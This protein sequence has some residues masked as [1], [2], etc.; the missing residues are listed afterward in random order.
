M[1]DFSQSLTQK[2]DII[3]ERWVEQVRQGRQIESALD[4]SQTALRNAIPLVLGAMGTVLSSSPEDDDFG[5]IVDGSLEHGVC[6]AH[7]G[8]NSAEIAWEYRLLRRTIFSTL[9]PD[10][11]QGSPQEII[12]AFRIING[13]VDQA[14]SQC[15]QSYVQARLQDLEQLQA[16]LSLTN[17][18]LARLLH[19][20]QDQIS[21]LAHEL[22]T[23]LNSIIGY[24]ELLLRQQQRYAES[25]EG[26]ASVDD[27]IHNIERVLRNGRHLLRFINDSLELSRYE[28]GEIQLQLV[29]VD[30]YAVVNRAVEI[31]VPL[32]QA[33]HLEL[34]VKRKDFQ[35]PDNA[36]FRSDDLHGH[37]AVDGMS[38]IL[39]ERQSLLEEN[40]P[41]EGHRASMQVL[42]DPFRLQQILINLLGNAVSY[43]DAGSIQV[44]CV[45]LPG[46]KWC[47]SVTDTGIG[48]APEDQAR[49]FEPYSQ[50]TTHRLHQ[51]ESGT[52]LGL[53]IVS[54]LVKL[55][56]GEIRL[57]SE[58][59]VGSTFTV[60]LPLAVIPQSGLG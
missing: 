47:F 29:P 4:L 23:P 12:R 25:R 6:R 55:L 27:T 14:I 37:S 18:E 1:L 57:E 54:R 9:E 44:E 21:H 41:T 56:Q 28:A 3:V 59:G 35:S 17:Q 36:Y 30:I 7:Q 34:E 33:K 45:A 49:I 13:V 52:G 31:I 19:V 20:S 50:V 46:Q 32:A 38:P 58:L 48:I 16:Q 51:K 43:T 2:T 15:F 11:L 42:T 8:Y 40:R 22:K 10:L 60:T 39:L 24:S 5:T 53:A 26:T